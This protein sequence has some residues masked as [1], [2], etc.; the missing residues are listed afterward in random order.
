MK[1]EASNGNE[2][3]P[4]LVNQILGHSCST[5]LKSGVFQI[6]IQNYFDGEINRL[7]FFNQ[8]FKLFQ[9]IKPLKGLSNTRYSYSSLSAKYW[10]RI[11]G[12]QAEVILINVFLSLYHWITS[13]CF[14]YIWQRQFIFFLKYFLSVAPSLSQNV[15]TTYPELIGN[16]K[17]H[18]SGIYQMKQKNLEK[19]KRKSRY[20][21]PGKSLAPR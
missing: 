21:L 9:V 20:G 8:A 17:F 16:D 14:C 12:F 4:S 18:S 19:K 5:S 1:L 11:S 2:F 3:Y 13:F 10:A 15:W 6:S 7:F